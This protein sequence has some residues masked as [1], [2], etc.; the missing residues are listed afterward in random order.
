MYL[1]KI[2][3]TAFLF[4]TACWAQAVKD[5]T[6]DTPPASTK[7]SQPPFASAQ[8]LLR[9]GKYDEAISQLQALA[10]SNPTMKGLA[11]ELG[12]AYY[13]KGEFLKA[14]DNLKTAQAEDPSDNESIQLL[15]LSYY[16]AGRP[17]DAIPYLEK[18][19]SW[20]P[21]ANIDAAYILGVCYIQTK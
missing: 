7:A 4:V 15:G 17:A 1:P 21:R 5:S 12:A 16:L 8:A 14:I 6:T 13:Q 19:Q 9:E 18:V 10:A 20:F 3:L 2:L 11:R